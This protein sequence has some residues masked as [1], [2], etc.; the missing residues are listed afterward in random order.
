MS[1]LRRLAK[2]TVIYGGSSVLVRVLHYLLITPYLTYIL[3]NASYGVHSLYYALAALL[4]IIYTFR[5]ET[6][7][8]RFGNN[9][10]ELG[11]SF[12]TASIFLLVLAV[13]FTALL[14][15]QSETVAASLTSP[16]DARFVKWFAIIV[17]ADALSAIP[18]ARLRLENRP[19]RFAAVKT[20]SMV[21]N[22][23]LVLLLIEVWPLTEDV[24]PG[25]HAYFNPDYKLDYVFLANLGAS[26]ITIILLSPYYFKMSWH[27]DYGLWKR[28]FR[29]ALPLLIVGIAGTINLVFDRFFLKWL[30][31]GTELENEAQVGV[32][33]ACLRI[34]VLMN[35][36]TQAYNYAAEPFFF[37][38]ITALDAKEKY[39]RTTQAFS[40][41][42][43]MAVLAIAL[44]LDWIKY[45]I[46]ESKWGALELVPVFLLAYFFLGLYYNFSIWYKVTDRTGIGALISIVGAIITI[47]LN[48]YLIPLIGLWGAAVATL[49]CFSILA[50][51]TYAV[52]QFY[53][54][55]N[56]KV[57]RISAYLL[58]AVAF[59]AIA[60]WSDQW[61]W[62]HIALAIFKMTLLLIYIFMWIF[63][64]RKEYAFLWSRF[65]RKG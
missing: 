61:G 23:A 5:F 2:E 57:F 43:S 15:W 17:A 9:K 65:R 60:Y 52:G 36:M 14:F 45:I 3:A 46:H 47:V 54:T 35:L 30:L 56:Y 49:A 48:V 55:I 42:S 31:P 59:Y 4:M 44:N 16:E 24:F 18:F 7:F 50:I 12:S 10:E 63:L 25:L 26:V 20:M 39:A 22:L 37:K 11:R 38:Q 27:F 19:I 62:N 32:Y 33:T 6:A 29:Y 64:E 34:A 41:I 58:S 53:Y 40:L 1:Y 51:L 13:L 28:M 21:I 8:F